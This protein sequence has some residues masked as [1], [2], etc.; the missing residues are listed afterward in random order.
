MF[1]PGRV[2]EHGHTRDKSCHASEMISSKQD[3]HSGRENKYS[4]NPSMGVQQRGTCRDIW[5]GR[6]QSFR[7]HRADRLH[8]LM[9]GTRLRAN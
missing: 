2:F 5:C 7:G 1:R 9:D 4:P 3:P 6:G 8:S